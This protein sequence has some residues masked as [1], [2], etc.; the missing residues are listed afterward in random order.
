MI[1]FFLLLE[2]NL[3]VS[4]FGKYEHRDYLSGIMKLG[5]EREKIGDIIVSD[6]FADIIVFKENVEYFLNNLKLLTRFRKCEISEIKLKD[7]YIKEEKFEE[8]SIIVTSMRLDNFVSDLANTSRTKANELINFGRVL[9][10]YEEAYKSSKQISIN[11]IITIR[12]K[13]KFIV[14]AIERKTKSD[15][16]VVKIKKYI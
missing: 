5:I 3:I 6:S 10:N 1:R 7:I 11:D 13:G 4:L 15:K 9:I 12:G 8:I 2:L 16:F 14:A